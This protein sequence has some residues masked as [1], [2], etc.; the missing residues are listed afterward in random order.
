MKI[1]SQQPLTRPAQS[2]G[3]Q[4][5]EK[6]TPAGTSSS[7][8]A[9]AQTHFSRPAADASQDIDMARVEE[10]RDAIREGRLEINPER[11]ADGLIDSIR[12]MLDEPAAGNGR[13]PS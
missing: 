1:D 8:E 5:S 10:I 12:S 9:G 11:I 2:E 3:P 13:D 4:Q 7:A 6:P